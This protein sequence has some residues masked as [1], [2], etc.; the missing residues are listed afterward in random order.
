MNRHFKKY[1][2][3]QFLGNIK[4]FKG[5]ITHH[6]SGARLNPDKLLNLLTVISPVFGNCCWWGTY[7][8][9]GF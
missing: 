9:V 3:H 1:T 7:N 4:E 8:F 6:G 5:Y 2:E